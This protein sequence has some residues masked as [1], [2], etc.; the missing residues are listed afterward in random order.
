[1][2]F[3]NVFDGISIYSEDPDP[4]K[5]R[6]IECN[7]RYAVMAGR[8]REELFLLGS[9]QGLQI[10]LE[11]TANIDRL[12]S[13]TRGTAYRGSFSWIRPDGVENINE[14]VGMPIT[15]RGHSYSIGIDRDITE[16]RKAEESRVLLTTAL[17]STANGVAITDVK[18]N[19]VWVNKAFTGMTGYTLTEVLGHDL[20]I[21]KSG[22]QDESFYKTLWETISAGRVWQGELINKKKD[23]SHYTEAMTITPLKKANGEI[24][25]FIAI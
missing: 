24:T 4:S 11:D 18:G 14:Y 19:I 16:R 9:T 10:T 12:E 5:R 7:D 21:L 15:W 3:E 6:L 22:K 8:S 20:G 17:E 1:M 2:V 25:H 13:L 23:A